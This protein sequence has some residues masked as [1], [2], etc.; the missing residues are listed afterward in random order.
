METFP[1]A[2]HEYIHVVDEIRADCI[3]DSIDHAIHQ[4]EPFLAPSVHLGDHQND[5][6]G[7]AHVVKDVVVARRMQG[8]RRPA[9]VVVPHDA[10]AAP[11]P[12][13]LVAALNCDSEAELRRPKSVGRQLH[14]GP[15]N[16]MA[17]LERDFCA[18]QALIPKNFALGACLH[19]H[20]LRLDADRQAALE[21]LGV[22]EAQQADPDLAAAHGAVEGGGGPEESAVARVLTVL[23]AC[24]FLG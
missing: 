14:S 6:L 3:P 21:P 23:R 24:N 20:I 7:I 8:A 16:A 5:I 11:R 10:H 4:A 22:A 13:E 12:T 1:N 19:C 15:R 17:R 18:V 9:P 2:I